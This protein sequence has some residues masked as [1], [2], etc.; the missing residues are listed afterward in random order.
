MLKSKVKSLIKYLGKAFGN[1]VIKNPFLLPILNI[2]YE[3][4]PH[5]LRN[6]FIKIAGGTPRYVSQ[7]KHD[8]IWKIYLSNNV[9]FK[10]PVDSRDIKT[11]QFAISY[12][13]HDIGL[14]TIEEFLNNKIPLEKVF[15]D[16]GANLSLRSLYSL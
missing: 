4:A 1:L 16:I 12:K 13:W 7:P 15:L 2:C 9:Q 11:W 14:K 5:W 3:F 10:V 8:F 6:I